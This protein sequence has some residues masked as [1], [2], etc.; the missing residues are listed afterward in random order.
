M[1]ELSEWM[2]SACSFTAAGREDAS[3]SVGVGVVVSLSVSV[4][5]SRSPHV[6]S[7]GQAER[8]QA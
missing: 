5:S 1:A 4:T 3:M 2:E 8:M 7:P 6:P